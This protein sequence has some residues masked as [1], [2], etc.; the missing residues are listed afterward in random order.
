MKCPHCNN[1]DKSLIEILWKDSVKKTIWYLC[2]V[3]SKNFKVEVK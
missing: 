2:N 1:E 3:C